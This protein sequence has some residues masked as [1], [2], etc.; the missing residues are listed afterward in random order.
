MTSKQPP[1]IA[2]WILKQFGSGSNNDV[3]LGDLTEQYLQK[4]SAMWYWRQ[5]MRAI[6]VSFFKEIRG[7]KLLAAR[8]ALT[9]WVMWTFFVVF[10]FPAFTTPFFG[11]NA[12]GAEIQP[13]HPIGSAWTVLWAPVLL[14][15]SMNSNRAL[16]YLLWIRVALPFIAWAICGWLVARVDIGLDPQKS[17]GPRLVVRLHRDLVLLLAGSIILLNLLLIGPFIR[18]VGPQAYS[19]IGPLMGNAAASVLGI[20]LGGGL[21]RDHSKTGWA[22]KLGKLRRTS[23]PQ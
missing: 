15:S 9:G 18:F 19:F 6:P 7:H 13:M 3:L 2:T 21:L 11:G 5:A 16:A 4:N 22:K 8:A 12:V 14:P 23:T 17:S 10:I 20:L 1:K